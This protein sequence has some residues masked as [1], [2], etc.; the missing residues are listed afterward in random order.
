[1]IN[2]LDDN[3]NDTLLDDKLFDELKELAEDSGD[4]YCLS[5]ENTGCSFNEDKLLRKLEFDYFLA[6]LMN[7][8]K[9]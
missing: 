7:A 8:S 3:S 5:V 2:V 1:M 4:E 6:K 9:Q